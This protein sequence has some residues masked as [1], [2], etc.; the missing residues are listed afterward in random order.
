[1]R[2]SRLIAEQLFRSLRYVC[3]S[4]V[5]GKIPQALRAGGS[6][7]YD[8]F[9]GREPGDLVRQMVIGAAYRQ[10]GQIKL[11]RCDIRSCKTVHAPEFI[12]RRKIVIALLGKHLLVRDGAGRVD[13]DNVAL[14]DSFCQRRVLQLLADGDLIALRDQAA[15]IRKGGVIRHAAHRR[16]F[17]QP[18]VLPR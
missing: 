10:R 4:K 6:F 5:P 9:R 1:M 12:N 13:A 14:H 8:N 17:R 2:L 3:V 15:D 16:S 11:A 18:A 7:I